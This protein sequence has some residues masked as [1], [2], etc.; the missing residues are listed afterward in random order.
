[1]KLPFVVRGLIALVI[2]GIYAWALLDNKI[3]KLVTNYVVYAIALFV[4]WLTFG[5][6]YGKFAGKKAIDALKTQ[7]STTSFQEGASTPRSRAIGFWIMQGIFV[8]TF[9]VLTVFKHIEIAG[10]Q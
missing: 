2:G 5:L 9:I 1:M 7:A 3:D 10:M 6:L 8:L 4:A